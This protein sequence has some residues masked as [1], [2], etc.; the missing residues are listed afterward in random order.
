MI[1]SHIL[2]SIR[3]V[4]QNNTVSL[5]LYLNDGFYLLV[6]G[7]FKI[8]KDNNILMDSTQ[9][10]ESNFSMCLLN[11]IKKQLEGKV[12]KCAFLNKSTGE[13]ILRLEGGVH[14]FSFYGEGDIESWYLF[15]DQKTLFSSEWGDIIEW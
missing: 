10:I 5:G 15:Q 9:Y 6:E 12:I 1:I 8:N 2:K 3:M 11:K 13:I 14:F 7:N 4:E